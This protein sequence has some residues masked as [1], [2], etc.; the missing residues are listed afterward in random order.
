VKKVLL[1]NDCRFESAVMKD[2][3]EKL[4]YE[5]RI[6][7]ELSA[8]EKALSYHPDMVI[9]NLI[10]KNTQGD[11]LL[12]EIK[13]VDKSIICILSSCSH[14]TKKQF[15]SACVDEVINTPVDDYKLKSIIGS[16]INAEKRKVPYA[17]CPFCGKSLGKRNELIRFCPFCGKKVAE[18][19]D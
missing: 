2:K 10:M 3:L 7:D 11:A 4:N 1:V 15:S 14:V 19:L 13:N 16:C 17:F 9:A 5:V 12:S 18:G 6:S 8:V